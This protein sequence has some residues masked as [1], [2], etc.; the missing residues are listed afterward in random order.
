MTG[1]DVLLNSGPPWFFRADR[2]RDGDLDELEF[3]GSA[4]TFRQF[5]RNGDGWLDLPEAIAADRQL[6]D[7]TSKE[8]SP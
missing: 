5:D 6:Q 4:E 8:V 1:P 2:N 7:H 3:L